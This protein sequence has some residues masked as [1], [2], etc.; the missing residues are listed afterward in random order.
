M[1]NYPLENVFSLAAFT[2]AVRSFTN[3]S[4]SSI[5]DSNAFSCKYSVAYIRRNQYTVSYASFSAMFILL[6]KSGLL[7]AC[8]ASATLAPILVPLR[9]NCFE[10]IYSLCSLCKYWH[11][12]TARTA[13]LKLFP[14]IAFSK[15]APYQ[16][17]SI[18]HYPLSIRGC[19][20]SCRFG[21]LSTRGS[22][23]AAGLPPGERR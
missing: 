12:F 13:K 15:T 14:C 20:L 21:G 22:C 4:Q 18:I 2:M 3:S 23:S 8:C 17:L 5:T 6:M 9:I 1:D 10:R 7:C 16:S 11:S 19:I